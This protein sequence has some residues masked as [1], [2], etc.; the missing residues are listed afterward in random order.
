MVSESTTLHALDYDTAAH[1][2]ELFCTFGDVSRVRI[3]SVLVER[4]VNVGTLAEMMGMNGSGISQHLR[5][6]RQMR[7]VNTRH[8]GKEIYY[9]MDDAHLIALFQQG[10]EYVLLNEQQRK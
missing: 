5:W 10:V 7:L 1:V 9:Q 6:F 4:E 3:M 8:D 2:A